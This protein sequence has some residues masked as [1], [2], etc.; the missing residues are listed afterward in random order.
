MSTENIQRSTG[1]NKSYKLDRGGA[2]AESGPFIGEVRNNIDPTRSGRLQVYIE[3]FAGPDKNNPDLWRDVSYISPYYGYTQQSGTDQGAGSYTGNSQSYGFWGTPPDIGTKVVCFFASGDPNQGYYIGCVVE[4]GINHMTPAIGATSRYQLEEG[5]AQAGYFSNAPRLPVVEINDSNDAISANPRFFDEVKPIHSYVAGVMLQQGVIND[6]FR[7]PIGSNSQRESPSTVYGISTPGRPIYSGGLSEADIQSR[8]ETG[9]VSPQ[10]A[11]VIARRGGHTFVM[12]D[13]DLNGNDQLIRLRTAKGHQ[14]ILSDSGD[15]LHIMHA[16]GQSWIELGSEGTIDLY[17]TNSVNIRSQGDV[18]IHADKNINLNS[19]SSVNIN[20]DRSITAETSQLQLI[21][22]NALTMYSEKYIGLKSDG[23]LSLQN[24]KTGTWNG[25]SSMIFSAGCIDLNGGTA[26]EVPKASSITKQKL[27]DV[28]FVEGQGW[29]VEPT[30]LETIVSRAPTHEPYPLHGRGV[31][32]TTTLTA[33]VDNVPLSPE[34]E[35]RIE[36]IQDVEFNAITAEQYEQQA[37]VDIG[38][39]SILPEQVTAM[40]AQ[41]SA[42]VPQTFNDI[43]DTLGVGKYGF[44]AGQLEKAGF[45]KPGTVDYYL[46]DGT[47]TLTDVLQSPSVWTG[48]DS[49]SNLGSFLGDETLQDTAQTNLY[50]S[51][52]TDL[53]NTGLATGQESPSKLAGLVQTTSK[54]GTDG[55]SKWIADTDMDSVF[56]SDM[57]K[58]FRGAQYSVDF[59]TDKLNEDVKG[60]TSASNT[61]SNTTIRSS[62]DVAVKEVI[63]NEKV[64]APSYTRELVSTANQAEIS[65]LQN[66]ISAVA[67]EIKTAADAYIAA[68][69]GKIFRDFVRT[70]QYSDLVAKR[71]ALQGQLDAARTY[72]FEER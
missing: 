71:K 3:D 25:G 49:V 46:Q 26:P 66:A 2:P 48:V 53:K 6:T 45:L 12:D 14:I 22:Q 54:H 23:T 36:S 19:K 65:R 47:A 15:A 28:S 11:I 41:A 10:E 70:A 50:Q 43:S 60:Y 34:I 32:L 9:E 56:K 42:D 59:A 33:G 38:V 18:N 72:Q 64:P 63:N 68:N 39:G 20:G 24:T 13:G 29:T 17:A 5:S 4:P 30:A 51:S 57:D 40:L 55:V 61:S 1:R 67:A 58:T 31:N 7:G 69:P 27:P 35:S 37:P 8:L 44:N 62:V 16:N 52:L 21:G